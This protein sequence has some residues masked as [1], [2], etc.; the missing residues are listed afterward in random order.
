MSV[1]EKRN[2]GVFV[3]FVR[4][5][6]RKCGWTVTVVKTIAPFIKECPECGSSNIS[7]IYGTMEKFMFTKI[8]GGSV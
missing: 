8:E 3:G 4:C 5:R 1:I 7:K 6:C 2:N